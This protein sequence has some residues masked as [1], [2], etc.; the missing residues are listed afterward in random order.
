MFNKVNVWPI[1]V[2]RCSPLVLARQKVPITSVHSDFTLDSWKD[3]DV[4]LLLIDSKEFMW[5]T[6]FQLFC[7]SK[8]YQFYMLSKHFLY[9]IH[10]VFLSV[11]S[12]QW[13]NV[14]SASAGW[15]N[16]LVRPNRIALFQTPFFAWPYVSM[17]EL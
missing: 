1:Q 10:M 3:F 4:R 16:W 15:T 13:K 12:F 14:N 2:V 6:Y 7:H 8:K 17:W 11:E 9:C 5:I